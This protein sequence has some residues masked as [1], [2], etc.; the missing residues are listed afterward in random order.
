MEDIG[1]VNNQRSGSDLSLGRSISKT[2]D[3]LSSGTLRVTPSSTGIM[4]QDKMLKDGDR[5]RLYRAID[6][7][8]S[9]ITYDGLAVICKKFY[10]LNE[11]LIISPKRSDRVHAP[12]LGFIVV[13]EMTLC[14][15][16]R[17]PP[18][19]ELL[20]I[21]KACGI[22]LPQFLCRAI[23]IMVGLIVFF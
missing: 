17:F 9:M 21:F 15:G 11:V 10:I 18:A 12:P 1:Q 7:V 22:S 5:R 13:Y 20:E 2:S 4:K 6:D 19:P 16:L 23:T 8:V 14:A 3:N